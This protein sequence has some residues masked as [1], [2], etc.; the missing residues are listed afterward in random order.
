MSIRK[1]IARFVADARKFLFLMPD[2][3]DMIVRRGEI[4]YKIWMIT[5]VT[6]ILVLVLIRW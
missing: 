2:D 3:K 4:L 1:E 5:C 6:M